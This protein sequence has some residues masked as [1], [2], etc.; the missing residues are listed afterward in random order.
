MKYGNEYRKGHKIIGISSA[1]LI[2]G[3]FLAVSQ[4]DAHADDSG[5]GVNSYTNTSV[6]NSIQNSEST[7]S[8]TSASEVNISN[9]SSAQNELSN[10]T[11]TTASADVTGT[12]TAMT[13]SADATSTESSVSVINNIGSSAS[14]NANPVSSAENN[15]ESS[16]TYTASDVS[17]K[18][19]AT[20]SVVNNLGYVSDE[21][22]IQAA[23]TVAL[24]AYQQTGVPQVV[25]A[26]LSSSVSSQQAFLDSIKAGAIQGWVQYGVLPSVTAAQAIIESAWGDS[27]LATRGH[28]LF[29]IKGSYNGQSITMK[30]SEYGSGGYYTIM[31]AF[32]AYPD[33]YSSILDHGNFLASNSRYGNLIWNRSYTSVANDLQADGYATSP[34]YA[35]TLISAINRYGLASWDAEAFAITDK[36]NTG[37]LDEAAVI[38]DNLV[39]RGWHVATDS[40]GRDNDF[41][42]ILDASNNQELARYQINAT[43]RQ[44]V[45][46]VYPNVNNSLYSGFELTVPYT[47]AFAGKTLAIVSRYSSSSDGN[48]DY[49]DQWF[50]ASLNRNDAN[51]ENFSVDSNGMLQIKGWHTADASLGKAYHYLI[52]INA[53]TG[54]EVARTRVN[55]QQRNDVAGMYS[56]VYGSDL[57]G[58]QTSM[59]FTS[60]MA[61]I[62]MQVISRYS[63]DPNGNY[64]CVD[65]WFSPVKFN[66]NDGNLENFSVNASG[67]LTIKGWHAADAAADKAY[68]YVII[69]DSTKQTEIARYLVPTDTR[70]DVGQVYG[71]V[72]NSSKSG[73]SLTIPFLESMNG[74]NIQI[75]SRYSDSANG[76]GNYVDYYFAAK[77]FNRNDANLESY[78]YV[79]GK[80][81]VK[82]WNASDNS[83]GKNNRFIIV[84]DTTRNIEIGRVAIVS[85]E[86]QDVANVYPDVYNSDQSGFN[87]TIRVPK[88]YL[89]DQIRIISRYSNQTNGE[90]SKS[91]FWFDPITLK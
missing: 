80:L 44:D 42:I 16:S 9:S 91:D 76:E 35:S 63:S 4:L 24:A 72:Y 82:G 38:G 10:S 1:V 87:A 90:G 78:N 26:T 89:G 32:R 73:F 46:N 47:S 37:T 14:T 41:I 6:N 31:A 71:D 29:G 64:D 40:Q 57:S 33:F 59:M 15:S 60:S 58:F 83:V 53:D 69:F 79:N 3:A 62:P 74:D 2:C 65:Y 43:T 55:D 23:K 13:A 61:N 85:I 75:I 45:K 54:A 88:L 48:S 52:L 18:S 7:Q 36:V 21:S 5:N 50:T 70:T 39:I 49:V 12:S 51:L 81:T 11:A 30:T 67:N 28:N 19:S 25:T 66:R 34:T 22:E 27:G 68:H 8:L 86:R 17:A 20:T 77:T 56:D 84:Y